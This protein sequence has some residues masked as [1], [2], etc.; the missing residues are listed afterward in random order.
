MKRRIR[1]RA[2]AVISL[3]LV[4]ALVGCSSSSNTRSTRKTK[5]TKE[6]T[7]E[8][9]TS[10]SRETQS[11][12]D[13]TVQIVP[14]NNVNLSWTN[15]T[16]NDGYYTISAPS[17][18]TVTS[19]NTDIIGYEVLAYDP[20]GTMLVYFCTSVGGYPDYSTY[21]WYGGIGPQYICPQG[22][23]S[24]LFFSSSNYLGYSDLSIVDNLGQNGWG[25]DILLAHMNRAG[26]ASEGIL[27]SSVTPYNTQGGPQ[28]FQVTGTLMMIAPESEFTN[29]IGILSQIAASLNFTDQYYIARSRVWSDTSRYILGQMTSSVTNSY[30]SSDRQSDIDSQEQSDATL[31]RERVR[32]T[33]TGDI[34][35]ASNGWSDSYTSAGGSRYEP[36]GANSSYYLQPVVGTI[37]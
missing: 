33:V 18:W 24:S 28:M 6:T 8:S 23:V 30:Q 4:A 5:H 2:L 20:T 21:N 14:N 22:T 27:T 34:Y 12:V 25:G 15:F 16:S 10:S 35:Y 32:D 29:W 7:V 11:T 19:T 36:V 3:V 31:G 26:V 9:T 1:T 13:Q 17:G 37:Y